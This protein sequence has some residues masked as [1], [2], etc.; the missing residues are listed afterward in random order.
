MRFK[1]IETKWYQMATEIWANIGSGDGFLHDVTMQL[2]EPL[3]TH[4]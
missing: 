4:Q 3:V 1:L 2:P